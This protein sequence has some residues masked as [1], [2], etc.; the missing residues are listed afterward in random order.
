MKIYA[1]INVTY[2]QIILDKSFIWYF[3]VFR[4]S[5]N[6]IQGNLS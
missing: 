6:E 3:Y 2:H 5:K 1:A 4:I